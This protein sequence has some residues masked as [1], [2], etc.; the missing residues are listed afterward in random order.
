MTG[1][2]TGGDQGQFAL[3]VNGSNPALD[4][5]DNI[6]L[7]TQATGAAN[8]SYAVGLGYA[9]AFTNLTSN[10]NDLFVTATGNFSVGRT[11]SLAPA[12]GTDQATLA[13]W[14]SATGKDA[15]VARRRSAVRLDDRPPSHDRQSGIERRHRARCGHRRLRQPAAARRDAGHRRRRDRPGRPLHHQDR[16]RRQR[17]AGGQRH[18]HHRRQQRRRARRNRA[19][20][21]PTPSPRSSPARPPASAP[22]AGPAPPAR[23]RRTST[24]P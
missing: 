7:D 3:A 13:A 2:L 21:S 5:R 23:S 10:F 18:V 24:T 6:L 19:R 8:L 20:P 12:G 11:G 15:R 1:T 4:L 17:G 16:R 9:A 22:W 14:Q